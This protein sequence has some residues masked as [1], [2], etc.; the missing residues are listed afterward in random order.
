MKRLFAFMFGIIAK[1]TERASFSWE[2]TFDASFPQS[3]PNL[4]GHKKTNC[5]LTHLHY[6][7]SRIMRKVGLGKIGF[8]LLYVSRLCLYTCGWGTYS[9][10]MVS[11]NETIYIKH[12]QLYRTPP[13][14]HPH[15]SPLMALLGGTFT[16]D[17]W[18]IDV[19]W[20]VVITAVDQWVS[21]DLPWRVCGRYHGSRR[22]GVNPSA[23]STPHNY[24]RVQTRNYIK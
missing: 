11:A 8:Y 5:I 12:W 22:Q 10:R 19:I 7:L 15:P 2:R 3:P 14:P 1:L 6:I 16:S 9:Y 24:M 21:C 13:H 23:A 18:E 4:V 17:R 20:L